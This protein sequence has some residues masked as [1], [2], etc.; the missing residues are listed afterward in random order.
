MVF[1]EDMTMKKYYQKPEFEL[2]S[3]GMLEN[4]TGDDT[5]LGY[6]SN[7]FLELALEEEQADDGQE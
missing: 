3:L 4:I 2:I 1:E 7:P 6:G 5:T